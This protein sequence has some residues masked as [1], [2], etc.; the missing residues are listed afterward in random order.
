M[1]QETNIENLVKAKG[2]EE[3]IA[4]IQNGECSVIVGSGSL[5]EN[6]A[7]VIRDIVSGQSGIP[8]EKI[9]IVEAK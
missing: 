5:D 9:K 8:Y 1:K 2:F 6:S 3:C 7:I 4:S